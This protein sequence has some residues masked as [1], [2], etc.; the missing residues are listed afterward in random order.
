MRSSWIL[1]AS[2]RARSAS[3][4]RPAPTSDS[5]PRPISPTTAPSTVTAAARTRLTTARTCA[6]SPPPDAEDHA[7]A[8]RHPVPGA[9]ADHLLGRDPLA[10]L[11]GML[12]HQH[13]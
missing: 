2:A 7:G 9:A 5:S 10:L 12:L 8:D 4:S 11:T 1:R 6:F 13:M 3:S